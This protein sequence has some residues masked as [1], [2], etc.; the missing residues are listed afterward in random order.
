[1]RTSD[2]HI[3]AVGECIEHNGQ[4]FGLVAPIW[5][6]AKVCGA[7]LA[8]D[9]AAVYLPPP[10]FTSLKITGVD[11]FSAGALAAADES[12]DE[13]TLHDAKRGVYKKVVLRGDRVVGSV[14]YGQ[15]A[16]GQ[17]YVRLMREKAD[18]SAFRDQLVF[19]RAAAEAVGTGPE[20][21]IDIAAMPDAEQVCDCNGVSKGRICEAIVAKKLTTLDAVRAHTKASA[22]CGHVHAARSRRSSSISAEPLHTTR[23]RRCANVPSTGTTRCGARSSSGSL[24]PSPRSAPRSAGRRRTAARNVGRR[25]T[26]T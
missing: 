16:D 3:Y 20:P 2:P 21:R 4:V 10:V 9:E 19:G 18:I 6:Q 7:R 15:V 23:T 11:V 26:T 25:S 8:G 13:I 17:W 24:R 22:S 12:D 14:L 1:M 5:E